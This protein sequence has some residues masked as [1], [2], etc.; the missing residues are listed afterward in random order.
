MGGWGIGGWGVGWCG[1]VWC[2]G[3]HGLLETRPDILPTENRVGEF[4]TYLDHVTL[5]NAF[6]GVPRMHGDDMTLFGKLLGEIWAF[7]FKYLK[8]NKCQIEQ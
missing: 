2:G 4:W 1:V 7:C 3:S 8:P 6:I 5:L